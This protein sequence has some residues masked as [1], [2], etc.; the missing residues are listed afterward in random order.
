VSDY[1]LLT[2]GTIVDGTGTKAY[3]G[4]VLIRGRRIVDVS[5]HREISR[6]GKRVVAI[7][8]KVIAPGFVDVHSHSDNAPLYAPGD[9]PKI[10]QGVTTEIV[11]NCGFSLAPSDGSAELVAFLSQCFPRGGRAF[12]TLSEYFQLADRGGYLTN[13]AAL[14]GEGNLRLLVHGP[15]SATMSHEALATMIRYVQEACD[16]GAFGLS[17]G[18]AYV[19]GMFGTAEQTSQLLAA[20]PAGRVYATHLRNEGSRIKDSIAEALRISRQSGRPVQISHLKIADRGSWGAAREILAYIDA[21]RRTG[22]QVGQDAYPYTTSSMMLS[23]CLPPWVL[24]GGVKAMLMRLG[25]RQT[26]HRI[27]AEVLDP[28]NNPM[29]ARWDSYVATAGYEGIRVASTASGRYDHNTIA[30]L[31]QQLDIEPFDA[32]AKVIVEEGNVVNMIASLISDRDL[33]AILGHE[34]TMIGTDGAPPGFGKAPHPRVAGTFV[35]IL[36]EFVRDKQVLTL[37]DAVRRMSALP[38][39]FFGLPDRGTIS[40]GKFADLVIFDPDTVSDNATYDEPLQPPTGIESVYVGGRSVIE[41]STWT[42]VRGG[43]RLVP[44]R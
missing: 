20:M 2:G 43:E 29:N 36:G 17:T 15:G 39:E 19:P 35:K 8:G 40:I 23:S 34:Q 44:A 11:G 5:A 16:A 22:T 30:Q 21:E 1:V 27:A 25:D 14:V 41:G 12:R 38:A 26:R 31:A 9:L 10:R 42:G 4:D 24:D 28:A 33:E 13:I 3:P 6:D 18:L 32:L 37:E 7:D